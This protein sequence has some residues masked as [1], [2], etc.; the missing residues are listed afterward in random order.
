MFDTY[1][2]RPERERQ[3][4]RETFVSPVNSETTGCSEVTA[5]LVIASTVTE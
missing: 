1:V 3:W 5:Q 2:R 4:T